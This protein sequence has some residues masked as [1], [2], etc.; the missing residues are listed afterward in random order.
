MRLYKKASGFK[1]TEIVINDMKTAYSYLIQQKNFPTGRNSILSVTITDTGCKHEK[2][3]NHVITNRLFN[4]IKNDYKNSREHTNY[5]FVIEYPEKISQ[6]KLLPDACDIHTHI[7]LN[8]SLPEQ[9]IRHY[10]NN[11]FPVKSDIKIEDI[12]LRND[13]EKYADYLVKQGMKNFFLS[14]DSYNY[15]ISVNEFT[16]QK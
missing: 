12:T 3:L 15:K 13:K 8:T 16:A 4:T 1:T 10:L 7:V 14:N 2:D 11:A 6:G 9:A 5:L